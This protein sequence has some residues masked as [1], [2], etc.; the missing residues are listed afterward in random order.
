MTPENLGALHAPPAS[1]RP[2]ARPIRPR[3]QVCT[4]QAAQQALP[5]LPRSAAPLPG[6]SASGPFG[7][8]H[9]LSALARVAWKQRYI[10]VVNSVYL[11]LNGVHRAPVCGS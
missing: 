5:A 4:A 6:L 8:P 2:S 3:P 9:S 11:P 10:H 7:C 1:G